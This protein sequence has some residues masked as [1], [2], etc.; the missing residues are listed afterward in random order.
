MGILPDIFGME[1]VLNIDGSLPY[2]SRTQV[3]ML[4][5]PVGVIFSFMMRI[6]NVLMEILVWISPL[7]VREL[8]LL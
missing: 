5:R 4:R 2:V 1:K 3:E 6:L 8:L 7:C